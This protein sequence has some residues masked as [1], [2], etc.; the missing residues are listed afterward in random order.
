[1]ERIRNTADEF[2]VHVRM[3]VWAV[4]L[5]PRVKQKPSCGEARRLTASVG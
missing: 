5:C 3:P 2:R 4:G 1:M